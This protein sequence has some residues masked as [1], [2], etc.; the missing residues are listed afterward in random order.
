MQ[1]IVLLAVIH[2]DRA[3]HDGH[4][5]ALG[6]GVDREDR[7]FDGHVA[8]GRRDLQGAAALFG[9]FDDDAAEPEVN[10]GTAP[11]SGYGNLRA[12][13]QFN[14]RTVVQAE[15]GGG[16]FR[17]AD[18]VVLGEFRAG[19]ERGEG[20]AGDLIESAIDGIDGGARASAERRVLIEAP[21]R[22]D[23]GG[24]QRGG[25]DGPARVRLG[26]SFARAGIAITLRA[27]ARASSSALRQCDALA[28]VD[29]EQQ[30]AARVERA[31]EMGGNEGGEIGA[32][33]RWRQWKLSASFREKAGANARLAAW[34]IS[35][36][37]GCWSRM[38]FMS[39]SRFI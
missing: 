4:A 21:V 23:A 26:G 5:R 15:D 25:G 13:V 38:S 19:S 11:V 37:V 36:S 31:G 2:P 6:A 30:L 22:S 12:L 7:A 27:P 28:R 17:G 39:L 20:G 32:G 14:S 8:I 9:G 3:F 10:G 33:L 18:G 35:A 29:F 34:S 1:D 16:V 24:E